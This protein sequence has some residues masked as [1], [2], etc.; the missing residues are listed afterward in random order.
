[1]KFSDIPGHDDVKR[2][3]RAMVNADRI[4]HALL[5]EGIEGIGK[6][7]LARAFAQYVLIALLVCNIR[8]L[9]TLTYFFLS[10]YTKKR[11]RV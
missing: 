11:V 8:P 1:M 6:L 4:P 9:I 7:A 10:R 3:L 5:L 2:R